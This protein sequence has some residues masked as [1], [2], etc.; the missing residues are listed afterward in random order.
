MQNF[1]LQVLKSLGSYMQVFTVLVLTEDKELE[2]YNKQM[3]IWVEEVIA[4]RYCHITLF[5]IIRTW[6]YMYA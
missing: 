4:N 2:G 1:T 5:T 3:I 6:S